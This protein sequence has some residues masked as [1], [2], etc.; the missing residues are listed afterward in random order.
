VV[1]GSSIRIVEW[2]SP[3]LNTIKIENLTG[4]QLYNSSVFLHSDREDLF[5][6]HD[7]I[8]ERILAFEMASNE[9]VIR[10]ADDEFHLVDTSI[11]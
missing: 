1:L 7:S 8:K 9:R 2:F 10:L 4:C 11:V 6:A 3:K 5:P